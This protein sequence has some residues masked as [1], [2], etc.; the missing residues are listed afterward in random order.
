MFADDTNLFSSHQNINT[1][2][3]I[4]NEEL[5]KNWGLVQGK[6]IIPK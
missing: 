4:F 1:L 6:Q 5:K 3:K 2:L